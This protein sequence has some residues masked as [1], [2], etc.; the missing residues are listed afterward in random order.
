MIRVRFNDP[1]NLAS[2]ENFMQHAFPGAITRD[3]KMLE[4]TFP[5]GSLGPVTQHK[6]VE[7]LLWAWRISHRIEPEDGFVP[8]PGPA[9]AQAH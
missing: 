9:D 2:C 7:R 4:L 6:V 5:S 1:D 8:F 3:G